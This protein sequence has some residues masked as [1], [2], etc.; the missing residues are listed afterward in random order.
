MVRIRQYC[1]WKSPLYISPL[2]PNA[3]DKKRK[4]GLPDGSPDEKCPQ[5][6][7]SSRAE[8]P[9]FREHSEPTSI[10]LFY[11]LFFVA[12]LTACTANHD[13]NDA[14]TLATY[15]EFFAFLWFT[16]FTTIIFDVRF[17]IDSWFTRMSK[18]CSFWIM[19]A[20]AMST[21]HFDLNDPGF[22]HDAKV[23]SIILMSSRCILAV[24]YIVTMF[25]I[26]RKHYD[27]RYLIP[28][29]LSTCT[30]VVAASIFLCSA[31]YKPAKSLHQQATWLVFICLL[32]VH[33]TLSGC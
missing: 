4:V 27:L 32:I 22:G 7:L 24:Q 1:F 31:F 19:T 16:W 14:S 5:T 9:V 26:R 18:A 8:P 28:F 6:C 13:I 11:D 15:V 25:V 21:L 29:I 23:I 12:N 3:S 2:K 20:F 10:Q 30:H 17:A 33:S